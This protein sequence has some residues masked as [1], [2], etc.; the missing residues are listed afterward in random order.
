MTIP[1]PNIPNIPVPA[2]P[3]HGAI[4]P[5]ELRALG[6]KPGDVLDFSAS[7]SPIGPPEGVWE[8][9]RGV[10]LSTYPDPECLELREAIVG[11]ISAQ[12]AAVPPGFAIERVIVGNGSTEIFHLLAR[13]YLSP[14]RGPAGTAVIMS[15]TYGEY[16]GAC[17][18][19]GASL[20]D[21]RADAANG[22]RWEVEE[23]AALITAAQ[24]QIVILCNP[25][26][27][28]GVY[29]G[30][31]EVTVLAQAACRAG[32]LLV[33]DE[34]YL[35]FVLRQWDSL[36]LLGMENAVLVRSMTKDYAQTGLRL[37]YALAS[38]AVVAKLRAYQPDW[39]VNSLAQKAGIAALADTGYLPRA[40]TAVF[41]SKEFLAG[42]LTALGLEVPP[43]QANFLLVKVGDAAA[44]RA[45]LLKQGIVV[46]DCASFGLGQYIRVGIRKLEDC[47]RLAEVVE[48]ELASGALPHG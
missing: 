27:P 18:L 39:S 38:E 40:R 28:T 14:D 11:H 12:G 21:F 37:G 43:S 25:N 7:I 19:A 45:G 23:A 8:A 20:I 6:M 13:A 5:G 47:R 15:P 29:L 10:D 36:A 34:A 24:P 1:D 46:R 42:R 48:S 33:I 35:S 22:F 16:A 26:N 17:R 30:E 9:M 41:E 3:V 32:T 4:R 31:S 44:W 2:R